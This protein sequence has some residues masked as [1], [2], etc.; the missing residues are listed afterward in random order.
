MYLLK[1]KLITERWQTVM[2]T[3]DTLELKNTR[4]N[5]K[6]CK[7][8]NSWQ[9]KAILGELV[10]DDKLREACFITLAVNTPLTAS[11]ILQLKL[12]NFDVP[13]YITGKDT[14]NNDWTIKLGNNVYKIIRGYLSNKN[15]IKDSNNKETVLFG[16]D[17]IKDN[18][19]TPISE[20]AM[21]AKI[22]YWIKQKFF[23]VDELKICSINNTSLK[24][25]YWKK[26]NK[27]W[28]KQQEQ[29]PYVPNITMGLDDN[30]FAE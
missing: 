15:Y 8:F 9:M 21:F 7:E 30:V 1:Y 26:F 20:S 24:S 6:N 14:N 22:N 29:N 10:K 16:A 5:Y 23:L 4:K 19:G 18:S 2:E 12:K 13:G 27:Y 17:N 3:C 11:Q 25:I 28:E